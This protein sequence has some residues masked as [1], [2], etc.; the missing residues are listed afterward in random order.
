MSYLK[1]MP[2]VA[3]VSSVRQFLPY[4]PFPHLVPFPL[5]SFN[6]KV[7]PLSPREDNANRKSMK[8]GQQNCVLAR[9]LRSGMDGLIYLT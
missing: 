2:I 9:F 5:S 1:L 3:N 4:L 6:L 8:S 7:N